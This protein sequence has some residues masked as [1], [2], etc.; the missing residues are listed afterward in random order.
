MT[1]ESGLTVLSDDLP[2]FYVEDSNNSEVAI[3]HHNETVSTNSGTFYFSYVLA[4]FDNLG[5]IDIGG[6]LS[7]ADK[8]VWDTLIRDVGFNRRIAINDLGP[9]NAGQIIGGSEASTLFL[10][11]PVTK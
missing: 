11:T 2:T 9:Q 1:E 3:G 10:L 4:H 6:S 7:D 8:L 5:V